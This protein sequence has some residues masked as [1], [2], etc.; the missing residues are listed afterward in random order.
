MTHCL[1]PNLSGPVHLPPAHDDF[2]DLDDEHNE[3]LLQSIHLG[4]VEDEPMRRGAASRANSVRFDESALQGSGWA[5]Q[6]RQSGDFGPARPT[7]G[8]GAQMERTLSHKSD[9]RHSSTGHSVHSVHS[10]ISGRASSLGLDTNFIIGGH[11]DDSPLDIPE[12]PPGFFYSGSAPAI[13]RCWIS[14]NF[15]SNTLLYAVVCTGSQKST[16]EYSLLKELNLVNSIHRETDGVHWITLPIF[17]AEARVTQPNS[18]SPSPAPQLPSM[19]CSFEVIGI[20]QPETPDTRKS[21]RIFIGSH[22]L[23]M[24]SAD[25]LFSQ[26]LMT[27]YGT[28]RDKLS[29][30]FV[31]PED[32]SIF[33]DLATIN[34]AEG[35]PRLN[36]TA[37]EFVSTE[38][39]PRASVAE[40]AESI[41]SQSKSGDTDPAP[42]SPTTMTHG[43]HVTRAM[44]ETSA[45]SESGAES[46]RHGAAEPVHKEPPAPA[47]ETT[48]RESS[49]AIRMPWRQSGAANGGENGVRETAPLSGYQPASRPRGMK[50]LKPSKSNSSSARTGA[51]YEPAPAPRSSSEFRRKSGES[52]NSIAGGGGSTGGGGSA[53][54]RWGEPK[55]NSSTASLPM[56]KQA[57]SSSS[58]TS[59]TGRGPAAVPRS[60]NNPL[61]N[62]SAFSFLSGSKPKNSTT[63]G[64]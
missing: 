5:Q 26:N 47:P 2:D 28:D 49:A 45:A 19:T 38:K 32:D 11:E 4:A 61:G 46:E 36:A 54:L 35:K 59:E 55:R 18:R 25:L 56:E 52:L 10:G 64:D 51:A 1:L 24:H 6:A 48:R 42:F 44:T 50:I 33:K 15:A 58:V 37:P 39:P 20:D 7:S 9:G 13:I 34:L 63:A 30:P 62:A 14:P 29:V 16:V 40:S 23:R 8:L 57:P 53:P 60:A 12:P 27:L 31:R 21:L 43:N 41:A 22:T 17:L 3:N